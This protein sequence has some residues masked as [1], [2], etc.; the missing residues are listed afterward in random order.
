MNGMEINGFQLINNNLQIMKKIFLKYCVIVICALGLGSCF[1]NSIYFDLEKQTICSC[2]KQTISILS[3]DAINKQY[4]YR[5]TLKQNKNGTNCLS[6]QTVNNDYFI[7]NV[8]N[9]TAITQDFKL[10]PNTEYEITNNT[11]GDAAG[12]H[13][14]IRTNNKGIVVYTDKTGCK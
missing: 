6:F 13:L 12:D 5:F 7:E 11:F 9:H 14:T 10:Q 4:Y 3:I 2:N 1:G 8:W